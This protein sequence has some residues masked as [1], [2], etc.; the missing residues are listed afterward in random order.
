L[1]GLVLGASWHGSVGLP[2]SVDLDVQADIAAQDIGDLEPFVSAAIISSELSMFDHYVPQRVAAGIAYRRADTLTL[3]GDAR[4]TDWRGMVLNVARVESMSIT[5]P[6]VDLEADV[7]DGNNHT[8]VLRSVWGWR[9]GADIALPKFQLDN[10]WRYVRLAFR[11]GF[12]LEP[13]P[14]V[15]QG[16]SSAFLDADRSMFTLGAGVE[17][18]DP[19]GL[20]DGALTLGGFFQ[21]HVLA[22]SV[23]PRSTAQ[24]RAGFPVDSEGIPLGGGVTAFG[25]QLGFQY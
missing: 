1:D 8:L 4:W 9:M 6:L 10:D 21:Y 5:S 16:R 22:E 18:W 24:P 11:G 19:L 14:L 7:I 2:I 23:L 12:A 25:V 20:I 13:T 17:T 15:E 3:Y